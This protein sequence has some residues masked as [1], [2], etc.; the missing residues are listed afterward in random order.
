MVKIVIDPVTRIEGHLKIEVTVENKIVKEAKSS[1]TLFRGFEIILKNRDPRDAT[2]ITQRI[3]GVCPIIHSYASALNLDSAFGI[4]DKITDNARIL[5]NLILG[6][7]F[8]QSHILHFYHLAALDYVK[9]PSVN[10]FIQ[11]YECDWRFSEKENLEF[12]KHYLNALEIRRKAHEMLAIFGGK[13]PHNCGIIAG[14]VTLKPTTDKITNFLFRLN[15]LRDFIDNIYIKD[16]IE[17]GKEYSDYFNLGKGCG[18]YLS[19]GVFDLETKEK[20]LTKRNRLLSSGITSTDLKHK[21]IDQSKIIED[22]KY[23]WYDDISSHKHPLE[24]QTIPLLNKKDAY[25]WIK[26]PRYDG[27]VYEVGPLAR[28][29]VNYAKGNETV[30]EI[31]LNVLSELKLKPDALFSVLGRHIARA[32]E[33]K[34][35]ADNMASWVLQL[36]PEQP[37]FTEYEIP[38]ESEGVGLIDAPRGALGHWIRIKNKVIENY[39]CVVPTT[40]NASPKDDKGQNGPIEQ[41]IIGTKIEDENNPFEILRIIRSFDPCL[42]CAVH[43][44]D[45]RGNIIGCFNAT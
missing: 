11:K 7:N 25:S 6:S 26:S 35:I 32:L 44:I 8:I 39:Q 41:A 5:R 19:Y 38:L 2:Q 43:L 15:E 17:I 14:G 22:L 33:T 31:V 12:T 28:I 16:V 3:C 21:N 27:E 10:P 24:E 4:D 13:V 20:E 40:W 37:W 36:K 18:N 1:G 30:K 42:A 45:I 9:P 23:S 34:I 29:L